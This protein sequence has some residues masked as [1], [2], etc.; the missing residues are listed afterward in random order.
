MFGLL[1][2][3]PTL[4]YSC[5]LSALLSCAWTAAVAE[6]QP[7]FADHNDLHLVI[8]A[9]ISELIR[10]KT[11]EPEVDRVVRYLD[12]NDSAVELPVRIRTRAKSRLSYC[13]FPPL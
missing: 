1:V 12:E 2:F 13:H 11:K 4:V 5:L 10:N 6:S 7:L 9:P 3:R 8:E